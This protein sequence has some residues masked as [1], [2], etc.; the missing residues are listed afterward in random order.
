[1]FWYTNI[2]CIYQLIFS[3]LNNIKNMYIHPENFVSRTFHIIALAAIYLNCRQGCFFNTV[4][5]SKVCKKK[6][7][8]RVKF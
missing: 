8:F 2:K 3:I 1:M 5:T 4:I 7:T 6:T